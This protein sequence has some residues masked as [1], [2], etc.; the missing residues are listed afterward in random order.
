MFLPP[1]SSGQEMSSTTKVFLLTPYLNLQGP[2]S[3]FRHKEEE[4]DQGTHC[5]LRI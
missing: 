1:P 2:G 3:S 4:F 5:T